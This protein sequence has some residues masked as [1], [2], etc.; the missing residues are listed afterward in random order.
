MLSPLFYIIIIDDVCFSIILVLEIMQK[1][2]YIIDLYVT[3][4]IMFLAMTV[5][6]FYLRPTVGQFSDFSCSSRSLLAAW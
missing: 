3:L 4:Y 2:V 5:Y 1:C 6:Y